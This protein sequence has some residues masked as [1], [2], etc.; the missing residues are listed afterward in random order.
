MSEIDRKRFVLGV[1][2]DACELFASFLGSTNGTQA[3][4]KA[5]G[6]KP[7]K[8]NGLVTHDRLLKMNIVVITLRVMIITRSV[9]ATRGEE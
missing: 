5:D 2:P 8:N 4:Q 3:G 1:G 7:E 9:M 6:D